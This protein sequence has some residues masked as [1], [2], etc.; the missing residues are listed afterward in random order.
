MLKTITAAILTLASA[1]A[2]AKGPVEIVISA[3]KAADFMRGPYMNETMDGRCFRVPE[4][5]EFTGLIEQGYAISGLL[6]ETGVESQDCKV[7]YLLSHPVYGALEY[8]H[9]ENCKF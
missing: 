9:V 5:A 3:D 4:E 6:I 8:G 1:T 7:H 2:F